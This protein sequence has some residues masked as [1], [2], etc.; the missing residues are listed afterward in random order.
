M[1]GKARQ[2]EGILVR[3]ADN[4]FEEFPDAHENVR[5]ATSREGFPEVSMY[6]RRRLKHCMS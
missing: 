2:R 6:L 1:V 5:E 4:M 3:R